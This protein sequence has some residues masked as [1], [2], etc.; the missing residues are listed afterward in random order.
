VR[1]A[2]AGN[3]TGDPVEVR[4]GLE[5]EAGAD[6]V[7]LLEL[8]PE[9]AQGL[10]EQQRAE[11]APALLVRTIVL[12]P[13]GWRGELSARELFG[14]L[15]IDGALIRRVAAD[16][17]RSL[18]VL[19]KGDLVR[20]FE[21]GVR[22]GSSF[23]A[24]TESRLAILDQQVANAISRWPP[25]FD[26]LLERAMRRVRRLGAQAA[27]DSRVGIE[28]RVLLTLMH[29]A[30]RCG[31]RTAEG[32]VVPLPLSHQMLAEMVGA[33]R[34]SVSTALS[35]LASSGALKRTDKRG[36]IVTAVPRRKDRSPGGRMRTAPAP[37]R[38]RQS[39]RAR[40]SG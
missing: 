12:E 8:D 19:T 37:A 27:L 15:V 4:P 5:R 18:E 16:R 34:P 30:E 9:L 3:G 13:K 38:A 17:G 33:Q 22:N 31:R 26:A 6:A 35:R 20:P 36:W 11:A 14:L 1:E 23:S 24:L 28:R 10:S 32:V 2:H 25:L 40:R 39:T 29:L 21:E 7:S